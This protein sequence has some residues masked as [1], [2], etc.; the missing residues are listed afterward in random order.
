MT[1]N[2]NLVE[3][4]LAKETKQITT[5]HLNKV[6]GQVKLTDGDGSQCKYLGVGTD[7]G[8]TGTFWKF[9]IG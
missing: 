4:M 9:S 8:H 6:Q 2:I 3:V 7:G 5:V 1:H